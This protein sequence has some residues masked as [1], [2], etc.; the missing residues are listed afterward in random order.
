MDLYIPVTYTLW[1]AT[2]AVGGWFMDTPFSALNPSLF[3]ALNLV[4]HLFAAGLVYGIL[5]ELYGHRWAALT[6]AVIFGVHP[7]QVETVAW[8]SGLKDLLAGALSLASIWLVV[9]EVN[10]SSKVGGGAGAVGWKNRYYILALLA[11]AGA[12]LSKPSAVVTPVLLVVIGRWMLHLSWRR[13]GGLVWPWVA[14]AIPCV[15][16]TKLVQPAVIV[17]TISPIVGRPVVVCDALGFYLLKLVWPVGLCVDYGRTPAWVLAEGWKQGLWAIPIVLMVGLWLVRRRFAAGIIAAAI[18][19]AGLSPVLGMVRFDFQHY[20]TVA[21]H[22]LYLPMLG[23]SVGVCALAAGLN[24]QRWWVWPG[25]AGA[26]LLMG[27]SVAQ[28]RHWRD[29][30]TLFT[31]VIQVNPRSWAGH[32]SLSAWMLQQGRVRQARDEAQVAVRINPASAPSWVNL[33]AALALEKDLAGAR[34][35][36]QRAI[37]ANPDDAAAHAAM[38]GLLGHMGQIDAARRHCLRA[39]ELDGGQATAYLNLGTIEAAEE[40][41]PAAR[42]HLARA[43]ELSPRDARARTN[44]AIVLTMAGDTQ[45]ALKQLRIAIQIDPGFAPARQTLQQLESGL[46]EGH[47]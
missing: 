46:R 45:A 20:S 31:R 6:G 33:G 47:G 27:L 5:L 38:G 12:L 40:N 1:L 14:L 17:A 3:H 22:Y 10:R 43:V 42:E 39:I 34:S 25:V 16:W 19:A 29:T 8:A 28:V 13:V 4:V 44:Y 24:R 32:N 30:P 7:V 15:I 36:Y 9:R 11:Y 37:E 35:A 21:D 23:V 2:A 41:W 18:F 26:V